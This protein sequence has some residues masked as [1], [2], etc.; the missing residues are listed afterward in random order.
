M[1]AG[2]KST[3]VRRSP[4]RTTQQERGR[5]DESDDDS[6]DSVAEAVDDE[7]VARAFKFLTHPRVASASLE[8]RI[9]FLKAKDCNDAE[10]KAACA[11]AVSA[12]VK[13][14]LRSTESGQA[15]VEAT[16]LL[17]DFAKRRNCTGLPPEVVSCLMAFT[18]PDIVSAEDLAEANDEGKRLMLILEQR[19]CIY[20]K[21]MHEEVFSRPEIAAYLEENFFVV[22]INLYGDLEVTDFDGEVLSEKNMARKWNI[23]FTNNY[24]MKSFH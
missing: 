6:D 19:G 18:F 4:R 24:T 22:R 20:C 7:N 8:K 17:A 10:I 11:G 1:A 2:G 21:Q 12:L 3:G 14:G 13:D 9:A 5:D 16:Q 15:A 23:M